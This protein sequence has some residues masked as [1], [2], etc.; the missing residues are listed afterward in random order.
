MEKAQFDGAVISKMMNKVMWLSITERI[1]KETLDE[2]K[3][4]CR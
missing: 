2:I 1:S 4:Y 3:E